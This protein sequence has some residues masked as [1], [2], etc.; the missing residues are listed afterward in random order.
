MIG[1]AYPAGYPLSLALASPIVIWQA[2]TLLQ[3]LDRFSYGPARFAHIM[4]GA[5]ITPN[6]FTP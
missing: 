1:L 3:V 4:V 6:P 5:V 2:V